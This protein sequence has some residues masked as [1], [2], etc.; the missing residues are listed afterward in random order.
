MPR[1][2][3]LIGRNCDYVVVSALRVIGNIV[4]NNS[5]QTECVLQAG[6][7]PYLEMLLNHK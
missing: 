5:D 2:V 1:L 6:C 7:I 3:S 4:I